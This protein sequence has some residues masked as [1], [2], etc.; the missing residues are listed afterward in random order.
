[1]TDFGMIKNSLFC[2]MKTT[3]VGGAI[4]LKNTN[5]KLFIFF[6][7]FEECSSQSRLS[8]STRETSPSGGALYLDINSINI[9]NTLFH[10]CKSNG[11]GHCIY[12]NLLSKQD[13]YINCISDYD[14]GDPTDSYEYTNI[15][16]FDRGDYYIVNLNLTYPQSFSFYGAIFFGMTPDQLTNKYI[17][18]I[19]S[20]SKSSPALGMDIVDS[21]NSFSENVHIE[22]SN[23]DTENEAIIQIYYGS[24]TF[25]L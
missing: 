1:M 20:K 6:C 11:Y 16:S 17:S 5:S 15:F 23:A 3:S 18:I 2:L 14:S 13:A 8:S 19:F 4:F 21:H 10:S 12:L 9:S 25:I 24:H 7:T 22:N